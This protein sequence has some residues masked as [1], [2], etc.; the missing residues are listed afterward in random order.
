MKKVILTVA[1]TGSWGSKNDSPYIPLSPKDIAEEVVKCSAAGA[2][3]ATGASG[4]AGASVGAGV[5]Q[6][7]RAMAAINNTL[8]RGN[9]FLVISISPLGDGFT[10]FAISTT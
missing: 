7:A 2:S 5:A 6:A 3:V 8:N 10:F 9:N 1:T 4:A